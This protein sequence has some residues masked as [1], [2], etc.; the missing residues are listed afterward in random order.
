MTTNDDLTGALKDLGDDEGRP[1]P[2]TAEE[3]LEQFRTRKRARRMTQMSV[4]AVAVLAVA[5]GGTVLAEGRPVG[6]EPAN[7]SSSET[8][9]AVVQEL[10]DSAVLT[11]ADLAAATTLDWEA[12]STDIRH[13]GDCDATAEAAKTY[14]RVYDTLKSCLE[15][16]HESGRERVATSVISATS[17]PGASEAVLWQA[18]TQCAASEGAGRGVHA[19]PR[20]HRP[21]SGGPRDR[22]VHGRQRDDGR[23]IHG[24]GLFRGRGEGA[25]PGGRPGG[26]RIDR[27]LTTGSERDGNPVASM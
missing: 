27:W 12:R 14:R 10:A 23:R 22:L 17:A 4:A 19:R 24:L 3:R 6:T 5:I 1:L 13:E 16:T 21:G 11:A 7:Q 2:K 25:P 26:H 18:V 15:G 20:A 8:P 9:A